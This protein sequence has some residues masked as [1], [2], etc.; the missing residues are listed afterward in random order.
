MSVQFPEGFLFG[1]ATAAYQIEGASAEDGKQDS[2]WDV[3]CRQPGRIVK[4]ENGKVACDHYHRYAEDVAL[5]AELGLNTYRFSVSWP[6]VFNDGAVNSKGMDFYSRLV[7]ELLDK[8]IAPWL[9]LYHWDLPAALPGGWTNRSTASRFV[10][11]AMAVHD[12]L[13]DRVRTWT[14]LNEPW[15]SA[16]LGHAS[17]EHAPGLTDPAA[18]IKAA[19]H[20]LLAHGWAIEALR[21]ADSRAKLGI[22]LNF[23]PSM[24]A[25]SDS[26]DIDVARRIDGTANRFFS[27]AIFKG[28]YPAD[29]VNDLANIW[30]EDLVRP[31][32]LESIGVPIDVLG[33][34]Y[35]TT[36]VFAAGDGT[37]AGPR[38][39]PHITAPNAIQV[40]RDLPLTE[41]G[42][43]V[44]PSGLARLLKRLHE[45]YT[46]PSGTALVIT[47]NGAAFDDQPDA[48]GFVDDTADRLD[49]IRR[50]LLS[51]HQALA[52][53]V[54]LRGY[55]AWSLIDNFEWAWGYDK[56]FGIVGVDKSLNRTPKASARWYAE[57]ARSGLVQTA[58]LPAPKP[59]VRPLV[60]VA[61]PSLSRPSAVAVELPG[62]PSSL[63]GQDA[64]ELPQLPGSPWSADVAPRAETPQPDVY[65]LPASPWSADLP[66]A[67]E[68]PQSPQTPKL[69]ASP[70]SAST[71]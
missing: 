17:G 67:S 41:M 19:H 10:E 27:D 18:S 66:V 34:N 4:G 22:T 5:M 38:P 51:A 45:D 36:N 9:T 28:R 15:C 8:G 55:L 56:R 42:W 59:K 35:Y 44:E 70:W 60:A 54:D 50:H 6:R 20:L 1:A 63:G 52:A 12:R 68:E 33:V 21:A 61:E 7:D 13:G 32:D 47:E 62:A 53:G 46:G 71:P 48:E 30:P 25:S 65:E 11:Y 43:E 39:S 57:V 69:P 3:F 23:T 31:G 14:T 49:F 40:L 29:V 24:P 16:F 58:P 2:I 26:A 64:A 37:K